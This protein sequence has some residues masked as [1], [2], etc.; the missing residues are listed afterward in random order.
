MRI[1][2]FQLLVEIA[3][4]GAMTNTQLISKL[5]DVSSSL[6][7]QNNYVKQAMEAAAQENLQAGQA[8]VREYTQYIA[9][10][11]GVLDPAQVNQSA[12]RALRSVQ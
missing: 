7:E 3:K 4:Q 9:Q 10:F 12:N 1:N 8:A 11:K 6:T 2:E 5:D